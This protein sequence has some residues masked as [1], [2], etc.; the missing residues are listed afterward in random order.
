MLSNILKCTCRPFTLLGVGFHIIQAFLTVLADFF[1]PLELDSE[2]Y[3]GMLKCT[4]R[5]FTLLGVV[6]HIIQAFLTVLA[7]FFLPLDLDSEVCWH[8]KVYLSTF[9]SSWSWFPHYSS[10]FN[11][12]CRLLPS[13]GAGF[14]GMLAC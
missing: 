8:V 10:I 2:V 5:P 14:R 11:S 4:C 6:F 1:L 13:F 7:D 9:Y 12:S 3:A